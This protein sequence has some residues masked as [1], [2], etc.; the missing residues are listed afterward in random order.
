MVPTSADQCIHPGGV[1]L[2]VHTACMSISLLHCVFL[3]MDRVPDELPHF[4]LRQSGVSRFLKQFDPFLL[5]LLFI[6]HLLTLPKYFV[7]QA[8]QPSLQNHLQKTCDFAALPFSRCAI[9]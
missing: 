6:L 5:I 3:M 9:N 7:L 4:I 1:P 2:P 8:I